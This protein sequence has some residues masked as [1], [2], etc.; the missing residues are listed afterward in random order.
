MSHERALALQQRG[1]HDWVA[2]L[3]SSSPG[4][5]TWE[6]D[7]VIASIVPSC[8]Q[9]SICNSVA[10]ADADALA[11]ALDELPDVY[12]GAGI[13]AWT[14]WAPE[15]DRAAIALLE[16]AGHKLDGSPRAMSIDLADFE[17]L[18]LGDLDWDLDLDPADLGRINDLAYV[19]PADSGVAAALV[20]LPRLENLRLYRAL[21]DGEP[22]C[23]SATLDHGADLGVYFVATHPEHRGRGL[24]SRLMSLALVQGR[25][26][27]LETSSLQG[28]PMGTPIYLRLGYSED[29]TMN[30]YERR[31]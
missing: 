20:G 10:Y 31:R 23:V 25:E 24:A 4:A 14:V 18:D 28:S 5:G 1:L 17:A 8:P 22:A 7:G 2:L 6:R 21:T 12:E 9:R 19:L 29:F 11:A 13:A 15:F 30:M 3:G 16:G 27:G 26:R